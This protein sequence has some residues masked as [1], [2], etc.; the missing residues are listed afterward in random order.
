MSDSAA[1][2]VLQ[3]GGECIPSVGDR[4]RQDE[5]TGGEALRCFGRPGIH[6]ARLIPCSSGLEPAVGNQ[7]PLAINLE[8]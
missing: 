3:A 4:H 6:I 8:R 1:R 7:G 5:R 2:G